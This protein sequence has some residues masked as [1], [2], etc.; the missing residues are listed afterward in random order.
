MKVHYFLSVLL[1]CFSLS[2]NAENLSIA[3]STTIKPIFDHLNYVLRD[4]K[5]GLADK[6]LNTI[7]AINTDLGPQVQDQ[8]RAHFS[9]ESLNI[10]PGGSSKGIKSAHANQVDIG[11]ASRALKDKEAPLKDKIDVV[12]LGSDALVFVA[13]QANPVSDV[14]LASLTKVF[15]GEINS[16]QALG[17][18]SADIRR[19]GKGAHHGT[20][21]VFISQLGLKDKKLAAITYFEDEATIVKSIGQRFPNGLA[22]GSLGAIPNGDIGSS[23]KVLAVDGVNPLVDGQFNSQYQYVRPLNL[24]INKQSIG[25]PGVEKVMSFF[26]T[27]AGKALVQAY[28]FVPEP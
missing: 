13:A 21:D 19:I 14:T 15:S 1:G 27:D 2:V 22:F 11:M 3:G 6:T 9:G 24:V 26:K 20:Y 28:G 16:W 10:R 18:D 12:K 4:G 17:G 23:V 8:I 25:K 5:V 7:K